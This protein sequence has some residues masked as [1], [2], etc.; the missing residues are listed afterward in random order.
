MKCFLGIILLLSNMA[1]ADWWTPAPGSKVKDVNP[2]GNTGSGTYISLES[3]TFQGC[4]VSDGAFLKST[5][6]DYKEIFAVI[7]A[8][9]M[10]GISLRVYYGGCAGNYPE[11]KQVGI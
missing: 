9:K 3:V 4:A 2:G 8:A 1:F 10:S 5:N 6:P 11:V 7:L